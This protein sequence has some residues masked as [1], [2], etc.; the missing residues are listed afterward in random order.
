MSK[1]LVL[2]VEDTA[3]LAMVYKEYLA[4]EDIELLH[5]STGIEALQ[6][7]RNQLPSVLLLDIKL[8]D[9]DGMEILQSINSSQLPIA[10]VMMTA[11][12]TVDMAVEAMSQGAFDFLEKPFDAK[13]L[14][15]TVCNALKRLKL[16]N[17]VDDIESSER[18]HFH[19]FIGQSAAMQTVYRIIESA[20]PSKATV[21]ITGESGTGKEVCA[22][23]IHKQS[24]RRDKPFVAINCGAIPKDLMESEIFGHVK[25]AFTGA[26]NAREGAASQADGGTLFLDEIGE[27][28]LDLQTKLLRFVQ[29]GRFQK[30]GGSKEQ[31]VDVRF[32]CATNRDPLAEVEAGRFREDLYYRLHVVP[33]HLPSLSDRSDD[34]MLIANSFLHEYSREEGKDF[35]SFSDGVE[36]VFRHYRWPG[37]VRQLQNVIR[38][39]IVL[40]NGN[41]ISVDHLPPPL[42]SVIQESELVVTPKPGS[43]HQVLNDSAVTAVSQD[44]NIITPLWQVEKQAIE[45]AITICDG[46]I[47][48]AA[49]MLEVSPSTIYRKKQNWLEE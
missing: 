45:R 44:D 25:G 8:P 17:L 9:M 15:A 23:A 38:N 10:V 46:N 2:L 35:K 32:V 39:M 47:P 42:N 16:Q 41:E 31:T 28:D 49:A 36:V 22:E 19:D 3:S 11:Y 48:R 37:N 40:N 43:S 26:V 18:D 13:R 30:V 14:R 7:I 20:A 1:P 34:I 4:D 33:I 12:G 27:M 29:T 5:A 24:D 6:I 21:F